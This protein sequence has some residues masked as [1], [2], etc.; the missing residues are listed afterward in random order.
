MDKNQKDLFNSILLEEANKLIDKGYDPLLVEQGLL[1]FIG[2]GLGSI[3]KFGGA[4]LTQTLKGQLFSGLLAGLGLDPKSFFGLA[5]TNT[6]ANLEIKDYHRAFTDC[7]FTTQL[8]AKS[9]LESFIDQFKNAQGLDG[10]LATALKE[11]FVEAA[12]NTEIYKNLA[13]KLS[14]FVCPLLQGVA[15][16]FDMSIFKDIE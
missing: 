3:G 6:F 16:K 1:D 2:G 13:G 8:I 15:S 9:I 4:G 12:A 14:G 11:T 7:D 5:L 10:L